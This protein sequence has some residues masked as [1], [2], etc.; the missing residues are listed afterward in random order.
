[1]YKLIWLDLIHKIIFVK[2]ICA[3]TLITYSFQLGAVEKIKL[4]DRQYCSYYGEVINE[5]VYMFTSND[6]AIDIVTKIMSAQSLPQNFDIRSANVP[7]AVARL[8]GSKRLILYSNVFMDKIE[9]RGESYWP[10]VTILAHEIGH[11]LAGHTLD[12]SL[13]KPEHELEA[14]KFS[15]NA[16]AR[17]GASLDEAKIAIKLLPSGI[18]SKSHPPKS[19]RLEAITTGWKTANKNDVKLSLSKTVEVSKKN[20]SKTVEN[21]PQVVKNCWESSVDKTKKVSKRIDY[22]DKEYSAVD[23]DKTR[24]CAKARGVAKRS[25]LNSPKRACNEYFDGD[26][27]SDIRASRVST[28]CDCHRV[29]IE[30]NKMYECMYDGT[31][32]CKA[33][34]T[35]EVPVEECS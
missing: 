29:E 4:N 12:P 14:D 32:M 34:E 30:Y 31:V 35:Y 13:M 33:T 28:K 10:S 17:L 27:F 3:I 8:K 6:Q 20:P 15:G 23:Y 1:M 11:H 21:P 16:V 19:A 5:D 26:E 25:S 7:N 18:K 24:S 9:K 2:N 22:T